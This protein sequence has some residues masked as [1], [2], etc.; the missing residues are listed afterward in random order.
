[1]FILVPFFIFGFFLFCFGCVL[2]S[3]I[4]S[5]GLGL[6]FDFFVF[7]SFMFRLGNSLQKN[8]LFQS[9]AGF[10]LVWVPWFF[11]LNHAVRLWF[12]VFSKLRWLVWIII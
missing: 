10:N 1:M 11:F 4:K 6:S 3:K 5:F 7:C 8:K 12:V 9:L 2:L